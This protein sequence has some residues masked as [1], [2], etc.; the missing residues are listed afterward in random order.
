A[1]SRQIVADKLG[2]PPGRVRFQQGDTDQVAMGTGTFGSRSMIAGGTA[3]IA[4]A[5]KI[6]AKAKVLAAHL[7]EAAEHDVVFERGRCIVAGTDKAIDLAEVAAKSFAPRSLPK[8]MEPG[9][10]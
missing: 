10:F 3:L 4:A 1:S 7:M 8:G 9:G 6:I 2:I 5:D